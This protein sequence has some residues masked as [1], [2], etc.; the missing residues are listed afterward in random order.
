M[1]FLPSFWGSVIVDS[2]LKINNQTELIQSLC[3]YYAY[4]EIVRCHLYRCFST[5]V[6]NVYMHF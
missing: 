4:Y 3:M 6:I 1:D 5:K 2:T